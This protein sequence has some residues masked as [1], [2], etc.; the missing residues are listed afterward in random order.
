LRGVSLTD[1]MRPR[2]VSL[3]VGGPEGVGVWTTFRMDGRDLQWRVSDSSPRVLEIRSV[4]GKF[5]VQAVVRDDAYARDRGKIVHSVIE[6]LVIL[7]DEFPPGRPRAEWPYAL[8]GGG[9]ELARYG[10]IHTE[11]VRSLLGRWA[12]RRRH[13]SRPAPN[14]RPIPAPEQTPPRHSLLG[15]LRAVTGAVVPLNAVIRRA[16]WWHRPR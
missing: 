10:I 2:Q 8:G 11:L 1:A 16:S 13:R 5:A 6:G 3:D 15:W 9:A 4:D 14:D 7:G 12:H